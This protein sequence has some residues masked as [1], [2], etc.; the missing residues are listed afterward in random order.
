[1]EDEII[2][3]RLRGLI[4]PVGGARPGVYWIRRLAVLAALGLLGYG[5]YAAATTARPAPGG[6]GTRSDAL[7]LCH[8]SK[9]SVRLAQLSGAGS[10]RSTPAGP[11]VLRLAVTSHSRRSCLVSLG[12]TG[13]LGVSGSGAAWFIGAGCTAGAMPRSGLARLAP[14]KPVT[15]TILWQ[16]ASGPYCAANLPAVAGATRF[17]GMAAGNL[18]PMTAA[19]PKTTP[20]HPA[21]TH[22]APTGT[23]GRTRAP[24][25]TTPIAGPG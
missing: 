16:Q 17:Y 6:H 24:K 9:V 22:P 25:T 7:P 8:G 5:G 20:A 15:W 23:T 19:A 3:A 10:H 14:A 11:P 18:A 1:M 21:P 4:R 2:R 12:T 13:V